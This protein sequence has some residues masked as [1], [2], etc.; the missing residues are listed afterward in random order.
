MSPLKVAALFLLGVVL[1]FPH[2]LAAQEQL[3]LQDAIR[4]GLQNNYDIQIAGRQEAIA[5]NN[6]TRG[7]AG[8]LPNVDARGG[9]TFSE[10][11][12]RQSFQ[13]GPDRTRNGASSNNLNGSINLNWTIFDGMGMFINYERLK[14]LEKSGALF[15]RETV[16]NT[17]ANIFDNYFEVVRQSKKMQAIEDAIAISQARVDIAQ[18]QYEVGVSAK[19]EI[20]RA[21]VDFNTDR[22]ELLVQQEALQNAKINLNQLLSRDPNIDFVAIDSIVVD[23]NLNYGNA[24]AGMLANNPLLSR[25][26]LNQEIASLDIKS[27]RASRFPVIGVVGAYNFNRSENEPLNEFSPLFNQ[28]RG[29]NYGLSVSLPLFRGFNTN[30]LAQN[31]RI[32]LESANLEYKRQQNLLDA[33]LARAYSQYTNR[34]QLLQLEETNLTL[35]QENA[36]IALERYRL[37]LLTAI[38]LREAQ[39]NQLVAENRLIDIQFQAKAAETELKRISSTLLQEGAE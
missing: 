21:Q 9:R 3:S 31:A 8:F 11:N 6:V 26:K 7:N 39:R 10:N 33:A 20:L 34:L 38:E 24:D 28:N 22:S 19:V 15:T 17:L 32:N 35:A 29:Y 27:V 37:G 1:L 25:L 23:P 18:A 16:Q 4:I 36:A 14:A 2:K 13:T 5:E 12:S 30:R